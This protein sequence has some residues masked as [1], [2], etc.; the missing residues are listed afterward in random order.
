MNFGKAHV[1]NMIL[2]QQ[3]FARHLARAEGLIRP[4]V[5][6]RTSHASTSIRL[7]IRAGCHLSSCSPK[8][9]IEG[10]SPC[11]SGRTCPSPSGRSCS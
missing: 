3:A 4:R 9:R 2:R 6:M 5:R 7:R 8:V 11:D 10:S 1:G